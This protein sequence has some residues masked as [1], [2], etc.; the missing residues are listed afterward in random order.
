MLRRWLQTHGTV[1]PLRARRRPW[2]KQI[3]A[4]PALRQALSQLPTEGLST[5]PLPPAPLLGA[6]LLAHWVLAGL[7][8]GQG[9]GFPCDRPLLALA[10]R[11]Q[12][13]HARLQSLKSL[14]AGEHW[15]DPVPFHHLDLELRK[16]ATDHALTG[17]LQRMDKHLPLF[18][19]RRQ[20]LRMAPVSGRQGL[21]HQGES[22]PM[23]I[24]QQQVQAFT[25][26]VRARADFATTPAFPKM[27]AHIEH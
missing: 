21:N 26:Q 5:Q 1:G 7:Q 27:I 12:E 18:E 23:N 24:L 10:R 17:T 16:L 13:V 4:D 19:Q 9:Y 6:Y 22:V 15:R 14:S 25:A 11:A 20:A 8:Q 2:Q 3:D